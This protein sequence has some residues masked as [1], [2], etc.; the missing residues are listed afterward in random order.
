MSERSYEGFESNIPKNFSTAFGVSSDL[1]EE[2]G[3]LDISLEN[4]LPLFIDPFLLFDSEDDDLRQIHDDIVKYLLFIKEV[5]ILSDQPAPGL[6]SALFVFPEVKQTW[7]G[8]SKNGNSGRG[9]GLEFGES[10]YSGL[11]TVFRDF[12][13]EK[14][15]K[16]P[17]MEKFSLIGS[18]IG[19]DKISDFATN[20]AKRYLLQYTEAFAKENIDPSHLSLFAVQKVEFDY[21]NKRWKSGSYVLPTYK[22]DY[23]LLT[24]RSVLTRNDTFINKNDMIANIN[25]FAPSIG[26]EALR[27][28][29]N[30]FIDRIFFNAEVKKKE[31]DEA[32]LSFI[33]ANPEIINYYLKFKEDS[34]AQARAIN[35]QDIELVKRQFID[36]ADRISRVLLSSTGFYAKRATSFNEALEKVLFLKDAIENGDLYLTLWHNGRPS[37]ERDIQLLFKL[38]WQNSQYDL[39]REVNNGRG[40]VDYVVSKGSA[41]KAVVEFK[42][43]KNS[44]LRQNLKNQVEIYK[45]ANKTE[46]GIT[47]IVFYT[48]KEQHNLENLLNELGLCGNKQIVLID[49]RRDNKV[50]ASN[51]R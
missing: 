49:A 34:G 26:D 1:I 18:S 37:S 14:T 3:A 17:H 43:A 24:P 31:R 33:Q 29:L 7:L 40:P 39:N 13:E 35:D 10:L 6:L 45:K 11:K 23:V 19:K 12:G 9:M 42:L 28:S 4:D 25:R 27:Y 15:L 48:E 38:V 30:A 36:S 44:K 20:F 51:V 22:G 8:F 16:S 32:V 47:V 2:Y 46:Y 50:S 41:D 21:V 5:A